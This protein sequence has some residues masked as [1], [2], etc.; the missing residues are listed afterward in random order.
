MSQTKEKAKKAGPSC[1]TSWPQCQEWSLKQTISQRTGQNIKT[2]KY[3]QVL[4]LI[5]E[6]SQE[7][8]N[9]HKTAIKQSRWHNDKLQRQQKENL[10]SF[11]CLFFVS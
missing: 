4:Y 3:M 9:M 8:T 1:P 10:F 11:F 7:R 6:K 5:I 2:A